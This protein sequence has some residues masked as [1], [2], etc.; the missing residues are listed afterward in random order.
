[1]KQAL[2]WIVALVVLG[3]LI[4]QAIGVYLFDSKGTDVA[5]QTS[6]GDWADGGVL[7]KG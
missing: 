1:M 7:F 5:Y 3:F 2:R 6:D 4:A